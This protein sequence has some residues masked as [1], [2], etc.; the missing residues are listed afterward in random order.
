MCYLI[1]HK[2][3]LSDVILNSCPEKVPPFQ[4]ILRNFNSIYSLKPRYISNKNCSFMDKLEPNNET[5]L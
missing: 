1:Q 4:I 3:L 5:L 2:Q